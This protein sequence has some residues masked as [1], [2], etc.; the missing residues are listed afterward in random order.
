MLLE[1]VGGADGVNSGSFIPPM[2]IGIFRTI[3]AGAGRV[4][5]R[6]WTGVP[7]EDIISGTRNTDALGSE[8]FMRLDK[9]PSMK[10]GSG[11]EVS[12]WT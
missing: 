1:S 12:C 4:W 8:Y 9:V 11:V 6:T 5:G 10:F 2:D 3:F 7:S